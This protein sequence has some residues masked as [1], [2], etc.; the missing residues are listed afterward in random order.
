MKQE[1][2]LE[3]CCFHC[4]AQFMHSGKTPLACSW[5]FVQQMAEK[6]S[7]L[8]CGKNAGLGGSALLERDV[9][10]HYEHNKGKGSHA[11]LCYQTSSRSKNSL[12][13]VKFPPHVEAWILHYKHGVVS[14]L[15]RN[16]GC[17]FGESCQATIKQDT[18]V[19][20]SL[21][22]LVILESSGTSNISSA[23]IFFCNLR[24]AR[25]GSIL[26]MWS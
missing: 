17:V 19:L 23:S 7:E 15:K 26:K 22:R 25:C 9:S 20:Y 10:T 6:F 11:T 21:I 14:S 18:L 12:L 3:W 13:N 24:Y 5:M 2:L 8:P 16:K 1:N 4:T